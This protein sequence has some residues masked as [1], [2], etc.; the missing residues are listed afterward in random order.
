MMRWLG[1]A[2]VLG[3]SYAVGAQLARNLVQRPLLLR[4]LQGALSLLET[5]IEYGRTPL[6]EALCR[7]AGPGPAGDLL[8]RTAACL[9]EGGGLTPGEALQAA[10]VQVSPRLCLGPTDLDPLHTLAAALGASGRHD[11]I[12]HL[13]LCRERLAAQESRALSERERWE[14]PVRYLAILAGA[15][16]VLLCI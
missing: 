12:R 6:P 2:L 14:R 9:A 3:A 8:R 13:R 5:E 15:A 4:D 11:Q 7:A 1:A 10:L 16:V